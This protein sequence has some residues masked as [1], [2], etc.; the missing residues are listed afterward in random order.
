MLL[1]LTDGDQSPQFGGS[2]Q[3]ELDA[4]AV[5][6][7]GVEVQ[8]PRLAENFQLAHTLANP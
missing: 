4:N 3:A 1:L 8:S 5:K 6:S 2:D 7:A